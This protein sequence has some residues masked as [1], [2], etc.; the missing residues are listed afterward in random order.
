VQAG[1]DRSVSAMS[2]TVG[3]VESGAEKAREAGA[4][5]SRIVEV[6]RELGSPISIAEQLSGSATEFMQRL[7][8]IVA[9]A[10]RLAE[11]NMELAAEID[12][13][14]GQVTERV[15]SAS[16]VAEESAASS[17]QVSASTEWCPRRSPRSHTGRRA[18]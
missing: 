2:A 12:R 17:E 3:D 11:Q 6:S 5:L 8:G 7:S 14:S 9:D 13:R 15:D 16:A 10:G 18:D 1:V 4:A